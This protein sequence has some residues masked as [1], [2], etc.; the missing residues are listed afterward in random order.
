MAAMQMVQCSIN[1][2]LM[3]GVSAM[4]GRQNAQLLPLR[5]VTLPMET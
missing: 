4:F 1:E 3:F 2:R 5:N